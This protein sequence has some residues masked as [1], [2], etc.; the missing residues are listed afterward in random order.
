[1]KKLLAGF[2]TGTVM[3][4]L[5]VQSAFA[6]SWTD[7]ST[8]N[9]GT[10]GT[11][12]GTMSTG[13]GNV[14]VA[15]SG[16]LN[17][18]VDGDYYYNNSTTGGTSATGTYG[19]LTPSDM[20]Q[21]RGSGTVTITFSQAVINPYIALV[22]IGQPG[23]YDVNYTFQNLQNPI[24]VVSFGPNYWGYGGYTI[25]NNNFAGHEFN[26]VLK[27]TG[28]YDSLVFNISPNEYWHGFNIGVDSA[29]VPEPAT[30][31][32]FGTGIAGLAG[33]ARRKKKA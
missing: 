33:V 13:S 17:N 8:I 25:T 16:L 23:T 2:A 32:L 26:G 11:G 18:F 14:G 19:G 12:A 20:I 4:L 24:E 28:T 6:V 21:E 1:M 22:S 3:A 15:L 7:W 5:T 10:N 31:L 29:A 30:M 27:L 9:A